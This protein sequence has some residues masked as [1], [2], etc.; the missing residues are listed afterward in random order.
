VQP[1]RSGV[2]DLSSQNQIAT[3]WSRQ[4]QM[5]KKYIDFAA[6]KWLWWFE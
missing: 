3:T 6:V 1:R 5:L 2:T 4:L